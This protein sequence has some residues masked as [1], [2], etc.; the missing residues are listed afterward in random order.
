MAVMEQEIQP[1][2]GMTDLALEAQMGPAMKALSPRARAFVMA[3][4][5]IGGSPMD[6]AAL[7]AGHRGT[8]ASLQVTASRMAADPKVQAA[9]VEEAKALARSSSLAAVTTVITIMMDPAANKK[10]RLTAAGRI[11]AL[12]ALEPEKT[13]NVNH[14]VEVKPT[15]REQINQVISLARDVGIDPRKLLGK[16]G[17]T[18][19]ADFAVVQDNTGLEDLLA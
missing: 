6:R 9:L 12:A 19:D 5:E 16:A 11:S 2:A 14:T 15:T 13:M 10:D 17:V 8:T 4:V 7:M 3:L 1:F 18:L